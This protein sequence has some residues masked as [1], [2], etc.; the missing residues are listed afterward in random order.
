MQASNIFFDNDFQLTAFFLTANNMNNPEFAG[1]Y[2]PRPHNSDKA[3]G[4]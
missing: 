3:T 2:I 1:D 4:I